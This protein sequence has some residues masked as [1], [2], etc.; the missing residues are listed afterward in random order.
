ML[1]LRSALPDVM[2]PA[3]PVRVRVMR[4][5]RVCAI[6]ARVARSRGEPSSG[7]ASGGGRAALRRR[8]GLSAAGRRQALLVPVEHT[9]GMSPKRSSHLAAVAAA[10]ALAFA[11]CGDDDA[12]TDATQT[13]ATTEEAAPAATTEADQPGEA[14]PADAA[15]AGSAERAVDDALSRID[16]VDQNTADSVREAARA[17]DAERERAGAVT[18]E[19]VKRARD[20]IT[21]AAQDA[22]PRTRAQLEDALGRIQ[23]DLTTQDNAGG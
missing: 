7:A 15:E 4:R 14:T 5:T 3:A 2:T 16:G 17:F 23:D 22:D 21:R 19:D 1:S 12:D 20:G 11:G 13:P 18:G 8:A 9:K 10:L 6:R